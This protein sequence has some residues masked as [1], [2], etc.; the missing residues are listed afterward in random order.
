LTDKVTRLSCGA[1]HPA[2]EDGA[3]T[4]A[5]SAGHCWRVSGSVT[6]E[7]CRA[8]DW[9]VFIAACQRTA[10][11]HDCM[12]RTSSDVSDRLLL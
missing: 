6:D 10:P 4:A 9:T 11:G 7:E 12:Q 3:Q 8:D 5:G 2:L 1:V